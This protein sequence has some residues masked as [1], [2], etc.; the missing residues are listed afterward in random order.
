MKLVEFNNVE[1]D[2]NSFSGQTISISENS[3]LV[4][5]GNFFTSPKINLFTNKEF[6]GSFTDTTDSDSFGFSLDIYQNI[7]SIGSP[8]F[9]SDAGNASL[10]EKKT[11]SSNWEIVKNIRNVPGVTKLGES[12]RVYKNTWVLGAIN[13]VYIYEKEGKDW[14]LKQTLAISGVFFG[15]WISLQNNRMVI[16]DKKFSTDRGKI[17]VYEKEDYEWKFKQSFEGSSPN[18]EFGRQTALDGDYF[19]NTGTLGDFTIYKRGRNG[20]WK[21]YFYFDSG[22]AGNGSLA[23]SKNVLIYGNTGFDSNRGVIY[24]FKL[25]ARGN[26]ERF[27]RIEGE[28]QGDLYGDFVSINDN[29]VSVGAQFFRSNSGKT[30]FYKIDN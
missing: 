6:S 5:S 18:E 24:A 14:P 10:Y 29:Y 11:A 28:V 17:Y 8:S 25:N 26:W 21:S 15:S 30:Y 3:F 27:D 12:V 7:F 4:K 20:F 22:I 9:N 2:P 13:I 16:S 1:G 23:L 19:A